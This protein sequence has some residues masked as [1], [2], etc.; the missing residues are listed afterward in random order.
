MSPMLAC[1]YG[2][3]PLVASWLVSRIEA[4]FNRIYDLQAKGKYFGTSADLWHALGLQNLTTVALAPYLHSQYTK[5]GIHL[6]N[7]PYIDEVV[8]AMTRANYNQSPSTI[9]A[10]VGLVAMAADAPAFQIANGTR[11]IPVGLLRLSQAT[12]HTRTRA[13]S[14]RPANTSSVWWQ[15]TLRRAN[16]NSDRAADAS[17]C[18][19]KWLVES[20]GS[21]GSSRVQEFDAVVIA[22][23]MNGAGLQV[24]GA[25]MK[26]PPPQAYETVYTTYVRGHLDTLYFGVNSATEIPDFVGTVEGSSAPFR[27]LSR[28]AESPATSQPLYKMFSGENVRGQV[29]KEVFLPGAQ[30][31]AEHEWEAYPHYQAPEQLGPFRVDCGLYYANAVEAGASCIETSAISGINAARL[32]QRDLS[33]KTY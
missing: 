14:V 1:R 27:S 16:A 19:H 11:Q 20:S 32:V 29:L 5:W 15:K 8:A 21:T 22:A 9:T 24:G 4:D 17:Q 30:V 3:S 18:S 26:W 7:K 28:V 25:P 10:L 12:L 13:T 23:P 31:V 6:M 2:M 33:I